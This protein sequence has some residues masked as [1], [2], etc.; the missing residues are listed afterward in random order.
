[1]FD[2]NDCTRTDISKLISRCARYYCHNATIGQDVID[3]GANVI[4]DEANNGQ[5]STIDER[6]P[7]NGLAMLSTMVKMSMNEGGTIEKCGPVIAMIF[8][9]VRIMRVEPDKDLALILTVVAHK[10]TLFILP[11]N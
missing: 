4:D 10:L 2:F 7:D 8:T 6:G 5:Y 11:K 9:M 3:G 1:M